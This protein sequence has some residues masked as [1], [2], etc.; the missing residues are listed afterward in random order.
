MTAV[1]VLLGLVVAV[2]ALLV[3]GLLRSHAEIL[4]RLHQLGAG[5]D[6][7]QPGQPAS[8][9]PTPV[10]SRDDFQVMPQMPAPPAREAFGGAADLVGVSPGG[11]EALS[12]R[13]QGV[14]HDT[15]VAFL[16]S[17]CIT[18]QKF[19]DAFAKPRKLKL[20]DG[21]RLVV[22]TKGVDGESP[23]SVASLAPSGFPTVMS[24]Q[25]FTDY[26]V[27]GSPYFVYVHGPSGRVRG[28]GTGPDWDQVSSLLS[29]ATVDAGLATSLAGQQVAKPDADAAREARIDR[30]L[31]EAGVR[32]GDPTLYDAG[33]VPPAPADEPHD[34]DHDHDHDHGHQ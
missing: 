5:L 4:K 30:E 10:L 15:I 18:C 3:V 8:P 14:E 9:A 33:S 29:Q 34:H 20:P 24:T 23:S 11:N 13:I 31:F 16:S 6:P 7:D 32:P 2:L 19:W 28:E 25:A 26:D 1:V 27:P 21:T 12:V 22:V 17:G